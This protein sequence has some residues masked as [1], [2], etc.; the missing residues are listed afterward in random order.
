MSRVRRALGAT[1]LV[2]AA[3][4][5]GSEGGG[6]PSGTTL[7]S[8]AACTSSASEPEAAAT[9]GGFLDGLP[10]GNPSGEAKRE[11]VEA[12][13]RSC[14]VLSPAALA[15]RDC[16]ALLASAIL[17]ESS[18]D[19]EANVVDEYAKRAVEGQRA[20]DPTVGLLQIRFSATVHDV[21]RFAPADA[22]ACAGCALPEELRARAE[23]AG[24]SAFWAVTG[25]TAHRGVMTNRACNVFMGAWYYFTNATGNGDPAKPAYAEQVCAGEGTG[26]NVVT[27]LRSHL[28]GSD[29]A[30]GIVG[31]EAA[32]AKLR[33]DDPDSYEYVTEIRARFDAMVGAR[34]GGHPFFTRLAPE[35]ARYCR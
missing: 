4:G 23:D 27:G 32:L 35:R 19:A 5:G 34:E 16:W 1:L 13:L 21:T 25:P 15:Q 31:D 12:I 30:N 9:I 2:L 24:D 33:A 22:L 14:R 8:G 11:I 7:A 28:R 26:A 20:E 6:A 29:G 10:Y 17:K 3:C 18:Y